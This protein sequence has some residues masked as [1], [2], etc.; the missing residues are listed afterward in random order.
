MIQEITKSPF[1]VIMIMV[2]I[3][4][5][6]LSIRKRPDEANKVGSFAMALGVLGTFWGISIGLSQFN[7]S[8]IEASIPQLLSGMKF[9][10][11]TSIIG[12]ASSLII[13][14]TNVLINLLNK[15]E[16]EDEDVDNIEDLFN[17]MLNEMKLLN[18]TLQNNQDKTD[19]IVLKLGKAFE[20][21][22]N[23]L[24][25]EL[26]LLNESLNN[27]QDVLINEFKGLNESLINKQNIL[28]DEFRK[29]GE[30]MA[31]NNTTALIEALEGVIKE[32]NNN[33]TEQF[34]ENFKE[35][36]IAVTKLLQWQEYYKETIAINTNQLEITV[37]S[38][39]SIDESL[40]NISN[41]SESLIKTSDTINE[42]LKL[43]S[44]SQTEVRTGLELLTEISNEAKESIPNINS[45][46]ENTNNNIKNS[47]QIL[48]SSLENKL[49]HINKHTEDLTKLV[50][51]S[52]IKATED[53]TEVINKANVD[54]KKEVLGYIKELEELTTAIN[55][56]IPSI[57]EEIGKSYSSFKD[58]LE[59]LS[60]DT[61]NILRL[62]T[63]QIKSQCE[64]LSKTNSDLRDKLQLQ[65]EEINES[66]SKQIVQIVEQ[67]EKLFLDRS[68]QVSDML[69][70]ELKESLN[71]LGTQLATLSGKFVED[72]T[73]LTERLR[74]VVNISQGV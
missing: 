74:E 70:H 43:V 68:N 56:N 27:K 12:M 28:I 3:V 72:Y 34:G 16:D 49:M 59:I 41:S 10:F 39:K 17:G 54:V 52:S 14:I 51:E 60:N 21:N 1:N 55:K 63:E 30:S 67:M 15:D 20:E 73:P 18:G 22:Q 13:K 57:S 29:F 69:E 2:G 11:V 65:I 38:I 62:S 25:N 61:N 33:L 26:K 45:Y 37:S 58:T 4:G 36:N 53:I 35:L 9:A 24:N 50:T 71:S 5:I 40:R 23:K 31:H 8:N 42:S 7:T 48:D 46:F 66:T 47:I 19:D 64:T 6:G 44:S 32:F